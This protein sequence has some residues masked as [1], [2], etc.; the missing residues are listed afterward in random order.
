MQTPAVSVIM[1][2]RNGARTRA[3]AIA[4]VRA[5]T[6]TDWELVLWDDGSSDGSLALAQGVAD[7][8][9]R[10]FQSPQ[11]TH[12]GAARRQ[13]INQARGRWIAF[14]DQDDLWLP[15]KLQLQLRCVVPGVVP[16]VGLVY[17]RTV[18]F[19]DS[20]S[21]SGSDGG[22]DG[23]GGARRDFDRHHEFSL[24]PEGDIF[25]LLVQRSCF[26]CMSSAMLLRDTVTAL[27]DWPDWL[28][29]TPDYHLFLAVARHHAARAVQV[30]VC[31]YRV[32]AAGMTA[33]NLGRIQQ[34]ALW[35]LAHWQADL[36]APLRQQRERVHHTVLAYVELGTSGQRVYGLKR[37]WQQG[38]LLFLLTRP[39]ARG[40]RAVR[41][42][43]QRPFWRAAL[44]A[45]G[46]PIPT[47][48]GD[49]TP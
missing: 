41:R 23:S 38:S 17:G 13:A 39:W 14:L 21:D 48:P 27:D 4:S 40:W 22:S 44:L 43:V 16:G 36:P 29:V 46:R 32:H 6:C 30:P 20:G 10:C 19:R 25:E 47:A 31:Q 18:A 12:L 3:S 28:H 8:R 1:N 15:D 11:P 26:I 45:Q 34:E 35:L 24:L 5:Q 7:A 33:A 37:L 2:V 9:I 49:V 42:R